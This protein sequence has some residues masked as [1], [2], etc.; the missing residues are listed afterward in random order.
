MSVELRDL[1]WLVVAS[2]H[3]SLRQAAEHLNVRQSTLSRRLRDIESILGLELFERTNGGTRPTL[4][5][6]EF[7]GTARTILAELDRSIE[8][9]RM[10][11]RGEKGRLSIGIHASLS[12]GNLFATLVEHHRQ[13]P[14]VE[15]R[16]M[17]GDHDGLLK[18]L[19][20]DAIDIAVLAGNSTTWPDRML[21]LWSERVVVAMSE[22]HPLAQ[23][24]LVHWSDL[25][26]EAILI[27]QYGPGKELEQLLIANL[28]DGF[29]C[30]VL[31]QG[32]GLDRLLSLVSAEYGVL[33]ML[34][35]GAGVQIDSVSFRE[36][37]NGCGPS[38]LSFAAYWRRVNEN[39]TLAP[40]LAMLRQRYPEIRSD[41]GSI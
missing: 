25:A 28:S 4:A 6:R 5:G 26:D 32:S 21:P 19:W 8:R 1:K 23:K 7:L 16:T 40:F 29:R 11:E 12:T 13:F 2:Q 9:L 33:L 35:G 24:D 22:R 10:S 38:R 41:R 15:V 39:P 37:H 30:N 14:I 17:D 31:H 34:E 3:R 27:P 18:A 20:D 36:V